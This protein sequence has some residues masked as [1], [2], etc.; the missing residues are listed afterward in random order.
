ML[1]KIQNL[2]DLELILN[3]KLSSYSRMITVWAKGFKE[4]GFKMHVTNVHE[5]KEGWSNGFLGQIYAGFF[6]RLL[7]G[8]R[9]C[10][11]FSHELVKYLKSNE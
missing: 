9:A 8:K 5:V 7:H 1:L 10:T 3:Q 4:E 2:Y 11:G 6:M